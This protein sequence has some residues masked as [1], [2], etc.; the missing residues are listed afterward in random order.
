MLTE[1]AEKLTK[2]QQ[3]IL[4][5]DIKEP[6]ML[7]IAVVEEK[8]K[9][10]AT[11]LYLRIYKKT[12][13]IY[14]SFQLVSVTLS[15][16]EWVCLHLIIYTASMTEGKDFAHIVPW[17]SGATLKFEGKKIMIGYFD[18]ACKIW[19]NQFVK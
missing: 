11:L 5:P 6:V 13:L 8:K 3:A 19:F 2:K 15:V 18:I 10:W 9:L 17:F 16:F 1:V 12:L 4:P 7:K 14:K